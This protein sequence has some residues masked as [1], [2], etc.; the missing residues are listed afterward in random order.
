MLPILGHDGSAVCARPHAAGAGVA[1]SQ[2]FAALAAAQKKSPRT[3]R[4]AESISRRRIEETGSIMLQRKKDCQ[5][6]VV[7]T[8]INFFYVACAAGFGG[9]PRRARYKLA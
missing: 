6:I 5:L 9:R 2:Q 3:G 7:M 4:R 1:I 8:D